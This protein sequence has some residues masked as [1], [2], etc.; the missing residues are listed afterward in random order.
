[1]AEP[2]GPVILADLGDNPGAGMPADGTVMLE[3]LLRLGAHRA[4][5]API[6]DPEAH[7]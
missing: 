5:V 4:V 1:M 6:N 3:A 2:R 7:N